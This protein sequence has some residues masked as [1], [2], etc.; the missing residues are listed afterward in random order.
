MGPCKDPF[1]LVKT[2]L[3]DLLCAWNG[4]SRLHV[5]EN[6]GGAVFMVVD[7]GRRCQDELTGC[8]LLD[9]CVF[10]PSKSFRPASAARHI[11]LAAP[12]APVSALILELGE[13]VT[14]R[15]STSELWEGLHGVRTRGLFPL[16]FPPRVVVIRE[17]FANIALQQQLRISAQDG[18]KAIRAFAEHGLQLLAR[19]QYKQA[20]F[21]LMLGAAKLESQSVDDSDPAARE[22]AAQCF[23]G[24][25]LAGSKLGKLDSVAQFE[26][27][28]IALRAPT[29]AFKVN[30]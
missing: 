14:G 1:I 3:H 4:E 22:L 15:P 11:L 10:V 21:A 12:A 24:L 23:S 27:A 7:V 9:L 19:G 20:E 8:P 17:T 16:L 29:K 13:L 6:P 26:A 25:A 2:M 30:K 5:L 28:A 18:V